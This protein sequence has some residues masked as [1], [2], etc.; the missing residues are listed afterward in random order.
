M[1]TSIRGEN[2]YAPVLF[3][4]KMATLEIMAA[5][6]ERRQGDIAQDGKRKCRRG[7]GR[8]DDALL[9]LLGEWESEDVADTLAEHTKMIHVYRWSCAVRGC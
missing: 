2:E 3:S 8:C 7:R 5:A 1:R 6:T 9:R 4:L